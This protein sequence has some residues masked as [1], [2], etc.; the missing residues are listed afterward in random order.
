MDYPYRKIALRLTS[1][2]VR[3]CDGFNMGLRV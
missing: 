3:H 2:L 1:Y